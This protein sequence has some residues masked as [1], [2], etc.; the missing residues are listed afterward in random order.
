MKKILVLFISMA[1]IFTLSTPGR[2]QETVDSSQA[3]ATESQ[4]FYQFN[5]VA[6]CEGLAIIKD[7]AMFN[8]LGAIVYNYGFDDFGTWFSYPGPSWTKDGI[9]YTSGQNIVVGTA[10]GYQPLS[11]VMTHNYWTPVTGDVQTSPS[12]FDMF[13]FDLAY[14]G[15]KDPIDLTIYTNLA[16]YH[17][18]DLDLPIVSVA[19]DF[20]GFVSKSIDEHFM[21][22]VLS[23]NGG[24]SAPVI[25]NVTLGHFVWVKEVQ[26]D[27][28]PGSYP[29][30]FNQNASGALPVAILGSAKVNVNDIVPDSLSL[31]GLA[32]K[33]AGKNN[34]LLAHYD[35][36]NDDMHL[37]LVVQFADSDGWIEPGD[38][39]ATL[40]GL[41]SD[42]T[43][44]E[45][46][47][48]IC[49]VP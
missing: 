17:C 32:V 16:T 39:Y 46:K 9:T 44:I 45:G 27:I 35:Y 49:I 40:A 42:G 21:G 14:L 34:K 19:Q 10:T 20:Y 29:N 36:V 23:S 48:S 26:I 47:D 8:S 38:G 2:S 6:D 24:G 4:S 33:V 43:P 37:D 41:L 1:F 12:S 11:N 22:Y 5:A 25:D 31:Q 15:R 18:Y 28:K 13:G 3:T 7:R 30:C